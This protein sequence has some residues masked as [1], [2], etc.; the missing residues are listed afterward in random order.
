MRARLPFLSEIAPIPGEIKTNLEDFQVE[1]VPAYLPSGSGDH[2][3]VHFEKRDLSTPDAV[4]RI[5]RALGV[6]PRATGYAGLKDKRAVTTQWAS[7]ERGDADRARGAAIEGIRVLEVARHGNKLRTGHL[8]ANRF[9]LVVRGFPLDRVADAQR[10]LDLLVA[11]GVPNGFGPQRYG[12]D[13]ANLEAARRWLVEGGRGPRAP[14]ERKLLVSVLQSSLFDQVLAERLE[15]GLF[16]EAVDGDLFRKE[17][18]GGLF[19]SEDLA[20]ARARVAAFAISPTG[21]M[22]G[23]KMRWP[24]R[25][26]RRREERVL[27]AGGLDEAKLRA[28][29][30]SGEGTRRPLRVPIRDAALAPLEDG[31]GV[32]VSFELPKGSY[33]TVVLREML[34]RDEDDADLAPESSVF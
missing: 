1:E 19:T 31:T 14:F 30:S 12:R 16:S 6:D 22:F 29:A 20:D 23:A 7:F 9:V 8:R 28:F 32:R 34:H 3:Y 15:E 21:P 4:R 11:R 24:E 2:L 27:A 33:A 26:A 13:G 5:A 10:T 25:E 18:T 17:D